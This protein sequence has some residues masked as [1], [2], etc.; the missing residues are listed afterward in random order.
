MTEQQS[1][2]EQDRDLDFAFDWNKFALKF[3]TKRSV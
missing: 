3:A 2:P 1:G